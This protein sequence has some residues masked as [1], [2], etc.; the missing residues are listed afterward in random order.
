MPNKKNNKTDPGIVAMPLIHPNAAGIDIG[1]TLHSVAVPE[2]RDNIRVKTFGTM[3]CDLQLIVDW[4]RYCKID[5]VAMESTGIYWKSIFRV[6]VHNGFEVYLVNAKEVKNVSGKKTDESDALWIQKLH[7]CGL[8]KSS[9]LPSDEQ[10]ALRTLVRYRKSLVEDGSRFVQRMQKSLEAMN[11]KVQTVVRDIT[12]ATGR[13]IVESILEGERN[14]EN[15]L[16][17]VDKRIKA[18]SES[19]L[20]SLEGNWREEQLFILKDSFQFYET[21]QERIAQCDTQIKRQL[22]AIEA[23]QN[24]GVIEVKSKKRDPEWKTFKKK[25]KNY[26]DINIRTFLKRIHGVDVLEIYGL[27]HVSALEILAETGSDLSKWETE[28]HFVSWLNL[29]PNNKI[30]GG[31]LISSQVMKKKP[32]PASMAFRN[33]ANA[34]QKGNHW[35][36][37]YFR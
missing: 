32:N 14:P 7:S 9:Y 35:L 18:D 17:H 16:V 31:K 13:R 2:G 11:I 8:L 1:S 27:G 22:E 15:F 29:C 26:P 19:I 28:K 23:L 21:Y 5:T 6:L 25:N 4:L 33:S 30:S 36:G 37:D 20:K 12:G 24:E 34:V 10:D 3:T